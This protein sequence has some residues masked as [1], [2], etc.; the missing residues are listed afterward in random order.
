L[1][2]RAIL[3]RL[4]ALTPRPV[5]ILI[6]HRAESLALCDRVLTFADG[7]LTSEPHQSA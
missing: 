1:G 2:E 4:R 3:A 6:A 5:I 7:R